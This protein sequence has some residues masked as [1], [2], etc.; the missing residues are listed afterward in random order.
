MRYFKLNPNVSSRK[1]KGYLNPKTK[2]SSESG[3]LSAI[4]ISN[5]EEEIHQDLFYKVLDR[6]EVSPVNT[7]GSRVIMFDSNIPSIDSLK[8]SGVQLVPI[9]NEETQHT[10]LLMHLYKHIDCVNWGLSEYEPWPVNYEPAE[11]EYKKGRFFISPVIDDK[12]IPKE[13]CA[14]RLREWGDAFNIV[15]SEELKNK[16]LLLD[17]DHSFLEFHELIKV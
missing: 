13:L 11:W 5:M 16:I 17:F 4:A 14:F 6:G 1:W 3:A 15:V 10:Y 7:L 9:V 2:L 12:R 8:V